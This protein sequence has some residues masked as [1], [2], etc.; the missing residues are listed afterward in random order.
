MH[1]RYS[2]AEE[3]WNAATHGFGAVLGAVGLVFLI[4]QADDVGRVG[5]L[6]AVIIY[7][8]AL[9]V[10][11]LFSAL[12]HA[13]SQPRA[14]QI[15]LAIDHCGIYLLIA[16]SY[17]PFSLLMPAGREGGLLTIVWGAALTGIL[18]QLAAFLLG[19]SAL[20]ERFAFV[21]YLALGWIPLLWAG[22]EMS[23]KLVPAG[24][25]LLVAG[26]ITF[27]IGVVFYLW[28]RLP[29]GHAVWHLFVVAACAFH[30]FSIFYYVVPK[31]I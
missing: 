9:M 27:S 15:L 2:R 21:F 1:L 22:G 28:K 25:A 11:F 4:L 10:L 29:Y 20:Y 16:G 30:F 13:V 14:K 23:G 5:S 7:G 6:A 24:L 3:H 31:T 17:T 8:T 19:R 12:H 18:V 26:G